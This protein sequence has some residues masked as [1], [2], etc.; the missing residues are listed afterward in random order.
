M[1]EYRRVLLSWKNIGLLLACALL[2]ALLFYYECATD[3]D[4]EIT[5][6]GE[7]LQEYIDQYPDF[8]ESVQKNAQVL[9]SIST[10]KEGFALQSIQKTMQ[11]Y[12]ALE[13]VLLQ[14]ADNRGIV[15]YADFQAAELLL[16]AV[17]FLLVAG[18]SQEKRKGLQLLVQSTEK[19]R[20]RLVLARVCIICI[21]ACCASLSICLGCIVTASCVF[22]PLKLFR[23]LQS[24]PAFSQCVMPLSILGYIGMTVL[25]KAAGAAL[26]GLFLYLLS[27]WLDQLLAAVVSVLAL[28][29]EYLLYALI[30][31]TD[32]LAWLKYCNVIALLR[33][34]DFFENY[35]NLNFF[36][37]AVGFLP[38]AVSCMGLLMLLIALLSVMKPFRTENA[39]GIGNLAADRLRSWKSKRA[40]VCGL[41]FWE[42]YKTL[43][44]RKGILIFAAVVYVSVSSTMQYGLGYAQSRI[45]AEYYNRYSGVMDEELEQKVLSAYDSCKNRLEETNQ[46]ILQLIENDP[47]SVTLEDLYRTQAE[48]YERSSVLE[49]FLERIRSGISYTETTGRTLELFC[50]DAYELLL[51]KDYATTEKNSMYILLGM[52]GIFAGSICMER[53]SHMNQLQRSAKRGRMNLLAAKGSVVVFI[54]LLL[55]MG[56]HAA[57]VYQINETV[58]FTHLDVAVQSISFLQELPLRMTIKGYLVFCFILRVCGVAAAGFMVMLISHFSKNRMSAIVVSAVVLVFPVLLADFGI[59]RLP[60]ITD[61]IGF[62][63]F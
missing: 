40:P 43:F 47:G 9:I 48:L 61:W 24:V 19:G 29:G 37:Y 8:L 2:S 17:V 5:L 59:L 46:R 44:S 45:L 21:Y 54:S 31:P 49:Y 16:V 60:V 26:A 32:R 22:G 36:G 15:L 14:Y 53:R 56:A 7:A 18:F 41:W 10:M 3:E 38:A 1:S 55:C 28:V 52:I 51:V 4:K 23:P 11:D 58:G 39:G 27:G 30:I 20:R 57:Q 62:C 13:G 34:N 6:T 35:K 50:A 33:T 63:I 12:R 25:I 42:L